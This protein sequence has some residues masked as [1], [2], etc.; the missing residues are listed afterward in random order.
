MKKCLR[1][2]ALFE[3]PDWICPNCSYETHFKDGFP[4]HAEEI[5]NGAESFVTNIH[6]SLDKV[7]DNFFWFK[8]RKKLIRNLFKKYCSSASSYLEIG[9]GNGTLLKE[10]QQHFKEMRLYGSEI[11]LD[12]LHNSQKRA[13]DSHFMQMDIKNIPF[14]NEFDAIGCFDV[15][16]H[17]NDDMLAL[18]NINQAL[19][20]NGNFI[21]TVPQHMSL[22]SDQDTLACHCRR[23]SAN[24][25]YSKLMT[26][27]FDVAFMSSFVSTLMPPI[28]L[29]RRFSRSKS[30]TEEF[31]ISPILNKIFYTICSLENYF[32][33]RNLK[34]PFGV[35]L[36]AIASKRQESS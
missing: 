29:S 23:Y 11:Y 9:C 8:A 12:A 18:K 3:K 22:W 30:A 32:I 36:I 1:C 7:E 21:I 34:I 17:I 15:L 25:L 4:I 20:S 6:D 33:L 24:E 14:V 5:L 31:E 13:P 16:E 27:G 35:S 2:D 28:Y 10:I 26:A 19:T